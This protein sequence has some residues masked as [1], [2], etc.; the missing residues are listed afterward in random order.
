MIHSAQRRKKHQ[1]RTNINCRES[2][3]SSDEHF[4]FVINGRRTL[5]LYEPLQYLPIPGGAIKYFSL[6]Y[7]QHQIF[8]PFSGVFRP[9]TRA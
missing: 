2:I 8:I 5:L 9:K 4:L 3:F 1:T 6:A 7:L